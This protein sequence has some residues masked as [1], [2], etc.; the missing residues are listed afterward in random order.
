MTQAAAATHLL[1]SFSSICA[2]LLISHSF[3]RPFFGNKIS[4][5][6]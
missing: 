3:T 4:A 6:L 1:L 5:F 2:R